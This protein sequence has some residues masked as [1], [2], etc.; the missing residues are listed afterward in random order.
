L[1]LLR[2]P[3]YDPMPLDGFERYFDAGEPFFESNRASS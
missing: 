1:T 3:N 2:L